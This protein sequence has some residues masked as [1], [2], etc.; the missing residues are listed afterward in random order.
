MVNVMGIFDWIN[1][2][3]VIT[4]VVSFILGHLIAKLGY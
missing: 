2:A 4:G 1:W 3:H